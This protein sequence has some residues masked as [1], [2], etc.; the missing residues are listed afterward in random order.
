MQDT[1]LTAKQTTKSVLKLQYKKIKHS[2]KVKSTQLPVLGY[3]PVCA[4]EFGPYRNLSVQTSL[5]ITCKQFLHYVV[6]YTT[7]CTKPSHDT[8]RVS[9]FNIQ[10]KNYTT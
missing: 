7:A 10:K 4:P 8:D 5:T 2:Y 1:L 6:I 9:N 3:R